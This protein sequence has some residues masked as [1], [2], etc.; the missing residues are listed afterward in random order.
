M[1]LET[2][3]EKTSCRTYCA[4]VIDADAVLEILIDPSVNSVSLFRL[5]ATDSRSL[6]FCKNSIQARRLD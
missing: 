1:W 3:L 2:Y 6:R 4:T 5:D